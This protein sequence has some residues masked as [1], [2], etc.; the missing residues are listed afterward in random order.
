MKLISIFFILITFLAICSARRRRSDHCRDKIHHNVDMVF[1][2]TVE[3]LYRSR[4]ETYR[5]VVKVKRVIKGNSNFADN[6]II[7]EG[8][9]DA[10]ICHSNIRERDTRIFFVSETD[11]GHLRLNS[12]VLRVTTSNLDKAVSEVKGKQ[13]RHI[14]SYLISLHFYFAVY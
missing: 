8:F 1:T 9:G 7:V 2:G 5:G 10:R 12:S 13:Y 3:K 11:S 6:T 4:S 14:K